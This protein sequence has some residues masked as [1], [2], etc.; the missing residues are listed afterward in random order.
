MN[1]IEK[2]TRLELKQYFKTGDRPTESE[3]GELLDAI[4]I[5]ETDAVF[6]EKTFVGLGTKPAQGIRLTVEGILHVKE[7]S[8]R[9]D[10]E[11]TIGGALQVTG[12]LTAQSDV[13]V[14]GS[15]TF[16][17][18]VAFEDT[19][20]FNDS[21]RITKDNEDV[22]LSPT[23]PS[24]LSSSRLGL[25]TDNPQGQLDVRGPL[26]IDAGGNAPLYTGTDTVEQNRFLELYNSPHTTSASGLKAGGILVASDLD[27]A[28]P[29]KDELIVMGSIGVGTAPSNPIHIKQSVP[30]SH[31]ML[32]NPSDGDLKSV[33]MEMKVPGR[34]WG[35]ANASNI[36][37]Q[38]FG[39]FQEGVGY[40]MVVDGDGN[41]GIGTNEPQSRLDIRGGLVIEAGGNAPLYTGISTANQDRFLLLYDSPNQVNGTAAS[42][43]KAGGVLVSDF[44]AYANPGKNDLIVKGKVGIGTPTPGHQLEVVGETHFNGKVEVASSY[45]P[46]DDYDL[47][48]KKYVDDIDTNLTNNYVTNA[49]LG[50]AL[51]RGIIS[52][53]SG[54]T[55]PSGWALCNGQN[56]T[57]DLQ[58]RFVVAAGRKYSV[59][60]TGGE[61]EITLT[62]DQSGSPAHNH[63][64]D[65]LDGGLHEHDLQRT[66]DIG[67]QA[68]TF[69]G[70]E[71][72]GF[73]VGSPV[74]N[75]GI[76]P[77][78][79]FSGIHG[80]ATSVFDNAAASANESH[81]NR[82]RF[83]ALA[84]IMKL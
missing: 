80:H 66:I 31:L 33:S 13:L 35:F 40:R 38:G 6:V 62:A 42:G 10:Q 29:A 7:A 44:Y 70:G 79:N 15:S 41:A 25:G 63:R 72:G 22:F 34:T 2:K 27:A 46:N 57:P 50:A 60:Q 8:L 16:Q 55:A 30:A 84:Y 47:V 71:S 23:G 82:P 64:V 21:L 83:Y 69:K 4:I 81:E 53:W 39:L 52:M 18:T 43:L 28:N 73:A 1:D 74:N 65:V 58:D 68:I 76:T 9:V 54:S 59:N 17:G 45:V 3:F 12:P 78:T 11:A 67:A 20:Q 36:T 61:D 37:N 77:T 56:G 14:Q 48:H 26:V 32:E 24:Y 5:Q 51:P 19:V 75:R 49:V